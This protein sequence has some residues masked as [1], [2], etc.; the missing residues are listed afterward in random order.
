MPSTPHQSFLKVLELLWQVQK[1][2]WEQHTSERRRQEKQR[3]DT[4][5]SR[6]L[7][8]LENIRPQGQIHWVDAF[9]LLPLPPLRRNSHLI[10]FLT[11]YYDGTGNESSCC[12]IYVLMIMAEQRKLRGIGFRIE[13]PERNC[14]PNHA[15]G[16]GAHD[17]YHAQLVKNVR[18]WDFYDTPDW[19]PDSQPSFPLW[20]VQPFDALLNLILTL[21][22]ANFYLEF[23]RNY[24]HFFGKTMS[25]EFISLHNRLENLL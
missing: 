2:E 22:G 13:S 20:A 11:I 23:L 6:Y 4:A 7:L 18:G 8:S 10:P 3:I 19:L 15:G 5:L 14:Q 25:S 21:Y 17:F 16:I 24:G 9:K 12:R 1:N